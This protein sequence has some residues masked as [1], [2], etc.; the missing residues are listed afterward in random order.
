MKT[1]AQF[2]RDINVLDTI[3]CVSYFEAKFLGENKWGK[4]EKIAVPEKLA[5]MRYVAKK[6]TTGFYLKDI[7]DN[8]TSRGSFLGF[9][10]ASDIQYTGDVFNITDRTKDGIAYLVRSYQIISNSK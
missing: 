5:K 2:K 3:V 10:K 8:T 6:D 9:P 4:L 1:L 7:G